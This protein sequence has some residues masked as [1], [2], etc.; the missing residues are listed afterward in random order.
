MWKFLVLKKLLAWLIEKL[1]Y[2]FFFA[3]CYASYFNTIES[4]KWI[5][6]NIKSIQIQSDNKR[7]LATIFINY[8]ASNATSIFHL[9]RITIHSISYACI[10][11]SRCCITYQHRRIIFQTNVRI[12]YILLFVRIFFN[13]SL[14]SDLKHVMHSLIA[15]LH[16]DFFIL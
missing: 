3:W 9:I 4:Q 8:I 5:S 15:Y 7:H 1:L 6:S 12:Y 10:S 14:R 13:L 16:C 11:S 2:R